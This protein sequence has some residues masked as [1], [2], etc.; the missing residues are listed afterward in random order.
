MTQDDIFTFKTKPKVLVVD[1]RQ[2]EREILHKL[3]SK[4]DVEVHSVDSGQA[5]L[6]QLIRD[7]YTLI[8]L[9][10]KMP[11]MDGIET[12][13]YIRTNP[14]TENI[15]IIF[16]TA[17]D[18]DDID[19]LQGYKVGAID[20]IIKPINEEIL[21][22]KV[23]TF[24]RSNLFEKQKEYEK[25]LSE[26]KL[27][28]EKLKQ[29]EREALDRLEEA[30]VAK[31]LAQ[32]AQRKLEEQ[33]GELLRHTQNLEQ[34]AY[35]ATH[36]LRAPII[37]LDGMVKIFEKRGYVN[38]EN[39]EIFHRIEHSVSRVKNTLHDLIEV[40]TA[41]EALAD[42]IF[43]L[44]FQKVFD[45]TIEDLEIQIKDNDGQIT[46]DFTQA[47]TIHYI[48]RFLKSILQ[49]LL[50]NAIKYRHPKRRPVVTVR[51]EVQGNTVYLYIRDNGMGMEPHQK[52]KVF[53]LFQRLSSDGTG[54]GMG[55]YIT[56][57]QVE[58]CGG[59]IDFTS[60]PEEGTE[61]VLSLPDMKRK[62]NE[63]K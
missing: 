17:Y 26:L 24:I 19:V 34:F 57:S 43:P 3:L 49:N 36:D 9:D 46:A 28:N 37:N 8:L 16:L 55:L 41:K 42:E 30:N 14:I 44:S 54:K 31:E 23:K 32:Q 35:V 53:G 10:I 40:V 1:D 11:I 58:V 59:N 4:L 27:K 21:L 60:S 6:H 63:K 38:S 20:Y 48:H 22:S 2:A 18:Q 47:P 33:K 45:E 61:F 13:R 25:I 5:A 56:K 51:T 52:E 62:T 39:E 50:T 15:P 7:E 29:A 12:A